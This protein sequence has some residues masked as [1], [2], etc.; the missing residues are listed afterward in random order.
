[1]QQHQLKGSLMLFFCAL[2][3]GLAFVAQSVGA[4]HVGAFTFNG[5]RSLV[6][7]VFL[8]PCVAFF[9]RLAGKPF[10]F[11]GT[12]NKTERQDLITGGIVC[13]IVLTVAS[14]LQQI[15]IGHTSV[16]KAGFITTLYIVI[17]PLL[18]LI[19]GKPVTRLQWLSVIIAAAGMYFICITESFS[20][21]Y[22][23]MIIFACACFFA[24]HI[25]A[26]QRFA[27]MADGVR[28]S[29][30]QFAVCGILSLPAIFFYE[31]PTWEA[32]EAAWLPI[33]YA[34]VMSCGIAYT[35]QILGQ[36]YVNVILASIILSMESV[37]SVL[38]GWLLL[39]EQLSLREIS[40][41]GL[42]FA[43]ILLAQMPSK[44]Q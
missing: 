39:G 11:W 35:L 31:T 13:G 41:C 21:N 19:A 20:V 32:L 16:G 25:I 10:S 22:G 18:G 14:T 26:I 42:V 3:W 8:I 12:D 44:R 23:D 6:G 43:A 17:V 34:G 24:L 15:G 37:F 36:K 2:I 27:V 29:L 9:D 28:M 7:A 5:I 30:L 38:S 33:M 4:D 40:G 1:M